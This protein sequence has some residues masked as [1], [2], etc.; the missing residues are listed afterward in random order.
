MRA[1][2]YIRSLKTRFILFNKPFLFYV[3]VPSLLDSY[4]KSLL[5]LVLK[6][7]THNGNKLFPV[8]TGQKNT[9]RVPQVVVNIYILFYK[10][11]L[12]Y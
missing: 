1:T 3:D 9:F 11:L 6:K 12:P 2:R 5:W 10:L 4:D 7:I 8:L